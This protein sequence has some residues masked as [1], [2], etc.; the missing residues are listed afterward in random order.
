MTR[1]ASDGPST[2]SRREQIL[3]AAAHAFKKGF[4]GTSLDQVAAEI[5]CTRPALYYHFR[6]KEDILVAIYD[7]GVGLLIDRATKILAE[8]LPPDVLLQRLIE[9]HVRTML[10][11]VSVVTVYFQQKN[12]LGAEASKT[13]KAKEVAFTKMLAATIRKG[14]TQGI[15]RS[16]DPELIVNGILGMLIWVHQWYRPERHTECMIARTFWQ[17]ISGG[18]LL[19]SSAGSRRR[20]SGAARA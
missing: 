17:L 3:E 12:S 14:Q 4:Q 13:V 16:G 19:E 10:Q 8:D 9:A 18:L 7:R 1:G 15:F 2:M 6:S 11:E 20:S 5:G